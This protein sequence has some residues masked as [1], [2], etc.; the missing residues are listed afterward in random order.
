MKKI[1]I[2]EDEKDLVD[3][4][5]KKLT[6]QGYEVIKS[7]NGEDGLIKIKREKPDLI[8]L[9]ILMP[10]KDGFDVMRDMQEAGLMSI[11]LIIISNSGQPVETDRALAMGARDFL[12]K[13]EFDPEEVIV[14][15][16]KILSQNSSLASSSK[17]NKKEVNEKKEKMKNLK[18][19]NPNSRILIVED[20][21]FLH[22]L[23]AK[24]L[25]KEGYEVVDADNGQE[26][27]GKIKEGGIDL[28]L[29]DL[30][31]PDI[32]GFEVLKQ[33]KESGSKAKD[34][35]VIILSNLGQSEDIEKG[36]NLGAIDFLVKAHFTPG[37]II[38]KISQALSRKKK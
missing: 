7:Y 24:K 16:E 9:D 8:L 3:V 13:A 19:N 34:T 6:N 21:K 23:I 36:M 14:K 31:L 33:I 30:I 32:N 25:K 5:E 4:L 2:I 18:N 37:E 12:V 28:I 11:P 15:I 27:L 22:E 35:P 1:L 29:L 10:K 20:D 38:D 26:A 17:N